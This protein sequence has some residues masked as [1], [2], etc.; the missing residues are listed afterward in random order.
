MS[1]D[2]SLSSFPTISSQVFEVLSP[3]G[4]CHWNSSR[5]C[6]KSPGTC[7]EVSN[8][9]GLCQALQILLCFLWCWQSFQAF[10]GDACHI[11][12]ARFR[13]RYLF[14][15]SYCIEMINTLHLLM[16]FTHE[17]CC[18]VTAEGEE[19]L[20]FIDVASIICFKGTAALTVKAEGEVYLPVC[21][22]AGSRRVQRCT[23][24]CVCSI[25]W[26]QK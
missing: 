7:S 6:E 21:R 20:E 22:R 24:E 10:A 4:L 8:D 15:S 16:P 5:A 3:P 18:T 2:P 17:E 14:L 25:V 1:L 19:D 26:E 12:A 13:P 11:C 9:S 23:A